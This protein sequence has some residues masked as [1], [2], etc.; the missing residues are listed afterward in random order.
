MN[1]NMMLLAGLGLLVALFAG[2]F[3][4]VGRP[5]APASDLPTDS[6]NTV[7]DEVDTEPEAKSDEVIAEKGDVV[8]FTVEG[9]NF[10]FA[11]EQM[12]AKEGQ[13]VQVT[14]KN[15]G[16]FHDFVIEGLGVK[17]K[18]INTGEEETI[19]FVAKEAGT[20]AFYCSV[21]GHRE[22]GMEGTLTVE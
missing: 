3:F 20:Y 8:E 13:T 5:T 2:G 1:K 21:P 22:K 11:P 15:V 6:E 19:E 17:T 7:V 10:K 9:S 12:R 16:G 4:F 14:F 18:R